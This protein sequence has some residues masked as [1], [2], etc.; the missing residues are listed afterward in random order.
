MAEELAAPAPAAGSARRALAADMVAAEHPV[1]EAKATTEHLEEKAMAVR[2]AALAQP[3]F[4][5][6]MAQPVLTRA[7]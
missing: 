5:E 2:L 3:V 7:E 6:A 1:L 4:A